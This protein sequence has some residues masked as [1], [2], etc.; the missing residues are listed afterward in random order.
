[1]LAE[2]P[3]DLVFLVLSHLDSHQVCLLLCVSRR[4]RGF[5]DDSVFRVLA[6]SWWSHAFWARARR[7]TAPQRPLPTVKLELCRI[8]RFQRRL[9]A[10]GFRSFSEGD[11]FAYW[12]AEDGMHSRRRRSPRP[13]VTAPQGQW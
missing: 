10:C 7:R 3:D 1:M 2:L 12:E 4:M 5:D 11:F 6:R 13:T 8:E 9:R